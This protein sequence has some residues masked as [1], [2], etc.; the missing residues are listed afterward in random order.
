MYNLRDLKM[1]G[2]PVTAE[3]STE[4]CVRH[5]LR[6]LSKLNGVTRY[7]IHNIRRQPNFRR[8]VCSTLKHMTNSG[9]HMYRVSGTM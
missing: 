9:M 3:K 4:R 7:R 6:Y 5:Y 1:D 2:N 8:C